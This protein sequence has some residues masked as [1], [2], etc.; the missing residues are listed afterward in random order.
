MP[1]S[2]CHR[3]GKVLLIYN[4]IYFEANSYVW[5]KGNGMVVLHATRS[6]EAAGQRQSRSIGYR[7][8]AS[9]PNLYDVGGCEVRAVGEH[10]EFGPERNS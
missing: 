7:F 10:Q 5:N 8:D 4:K 3:E 2:L 1:F 9:W 6:E